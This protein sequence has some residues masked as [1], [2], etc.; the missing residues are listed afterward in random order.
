MVEHGHTAGH[1][2]SMRV[3]TSDAYLRSQWKV[4]NSNVEEM[5]KHVEK[6]CS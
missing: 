1:D 4:Q 3:V 6:V 5:F 2:I